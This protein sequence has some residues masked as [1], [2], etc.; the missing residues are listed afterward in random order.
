MPKKFVRK[1]QH[2]IEI[3]ESEGFE[4]LWTC[5]QVDEYMEVFEFDHCPICKSKEI[6]DQTLIH[7]IKEK[8]H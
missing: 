5:S 3:I 8:G 7:V 4:P 1:N 2:T 6:I